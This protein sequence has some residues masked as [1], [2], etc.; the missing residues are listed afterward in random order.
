MTCEVILDSMCK[1]YK[2]DQVYTADVSGFSLYL[3]ILE[4]HMK[5]SIEE[6]AT[7]MLQVANMYAFPVK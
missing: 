5:S 6:N 1:Y 3:A 2:A 4:K 7:N